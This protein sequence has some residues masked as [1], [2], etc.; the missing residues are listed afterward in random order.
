MGAQEGFQCRGR[1]ASGVSAQRAERCTLVRAE[2]PLAV[3]VIVGCGRTPHLPIAAARAR[4]ALMLVAQEGE[5][6]DTGG[7][8]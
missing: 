7:T 8:F 2:A 5:G 6:E 1:A 3:I 4:T